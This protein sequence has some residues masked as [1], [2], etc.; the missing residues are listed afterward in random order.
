MLEESWGFAQTWGGAGQEET[1][2]AAGGSP[3]NK[4]STYARSGGAA[5]SCL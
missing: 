5:V 4:N 3:K 2:P 1:F